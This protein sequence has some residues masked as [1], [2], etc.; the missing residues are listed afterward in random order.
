VTPAAAEVPSQRLPDL[1]VRRLGILVQQNLGSHNNA[2]HTIAALRSL[3][4]NEC[5][6]EWVRMGQCFRAP[7]AL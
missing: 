7:P 2:V 4:L 1:C 5:L 3:L 6:L